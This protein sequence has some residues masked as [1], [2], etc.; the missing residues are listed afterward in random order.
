MAGPVRAEGVILPVMLA[1]LCSRQ[2]WTQAPGPATGLGGGAGEGA[3]RPHS[4]SAMPSPSVCTSVY[5]LPAPSPSAPNLLIPG[6]SPSRP[7]PSSALLVAVPS[8][9]LLLP[10]SRAI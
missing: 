6:E 9:P 4:P 2:D 10:G 3:P 8:A 7:P 5:Y 1:A